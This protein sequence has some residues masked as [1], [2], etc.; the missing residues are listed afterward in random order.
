MLLIGA[1]PLAALLVSSLLATNPSA[2]LFGFLTQRT[3]WITWFALYAWFWASVL[4]GGRDALDRVGVVLAVAL[5]AAA[6][7]GIFSGAPDPTAWSDKPSGLFSNAITF[8][9]VML[10]G[11][12]VSAYI[13]LSRSSFAWRVAGGAAGA[14]CLVG[15]LVS[16]SRGSWIG[17]VA[18]VAVVPLLFWP[19]GSKGYRPW[20]RLG[21]VLVVALIALGLLFGYV[22]SVGAFGPDVYASVDSLFSQR[23]GIWRSA[24]L[25]ISR[26]PLLGRGPAQFTAF[27][28]LDVDAN[29]WPQGPMTFA[30]HSSPLEFLVAGGLLLAAAAAFTLW[31]WR[32]W[33]AKVLSK[34][35]G[36]PARVALLSA[37]LGY[38][39][40]TLF[41][42]VDALGALAAAALLGLLAGD[43]SSEPILTKKGPRKRPK[44]RKPAPVPALTTTVA[45]VAV[46]STVALTAAVMP[47]AAGEFL[48]RS[49]S[50]GSDGHIATL[51]DGAIRLRDAE[52]AMQYVNICLDKSA[53]AD[54]SQWRDRA[55][56]ALDMLGRE[57]RWHAGLAYANADM[58]SADLE[59]DPA[60]ASSR[61]LAAI[62]AGREAA[63]GSMMWDYFELLYSADTGDPQRSAELAGR[64]LALPQMPNVRVAVEQLREGKKGG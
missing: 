31:Q 19:E 64:I 23:L 14:I 3:G 11:L 22:T 12:G 50:P 32:E 16:R 27:A 38:A 17:L 59:T 1:V 20:L 39:V 5:A 52:A 42:W 63:P 56:E 36:N 8:G 41:S 62:Q 33:P 2:S 51:R 57:T 18:A 15:I 4:H 44:K 58:S 26:H 29:L 53:E 30:P 48:I 34:A 10:L 43:A 35:R 24:L 55:R 60:G 13:A 49:A 6:L 21:S 40:A 45:V 61:L 47:S 9:Q 7:Y 37:L 46:A 28:M 25:D 54:G